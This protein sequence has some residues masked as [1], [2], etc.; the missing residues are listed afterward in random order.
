M[1]RFAAVLFDWRG[2]LSVTLTE[3]EWIRRG[4]ALAGRENSAEQVRQVH[5]RI[6]GSPFLARLAGPNIDAD[7]HVH[8]QAYFDVFQDAGLDPKLAAALYAVESDARLNPFADDV[9][10]TLTGI[11]AMGVRVG[12]I[13]DIHVDI[14]PAFEDAGLAELVDVFVLSFKHGVQKPQ[15][16]IFH[17]A[18]QQLGIEPHQA[19]M[20]GDRAAYDGAAVQAGLV[21]LLLPPL[22]STSDRRLLHVLALLG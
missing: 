22:R 20:V 14:R 7:A 12:V 2:T 10:S 1:S 17:V 13:S 8:R 4:L 15:P 21:T 18:L 6:G 19:L 11:R 5:A 3:Q 16:E 9:A